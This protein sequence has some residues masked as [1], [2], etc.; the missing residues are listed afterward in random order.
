MGQITRSALWVYI[1]S[2]ISGV[3]GYVFWI[4]ASTF[5]SPNAVGSA[6]AILAFQ[7]L[8]I[9]VSSLGIPTGVKRFVGWMQKGDDYG[10]GSSYFVT[11]VAMIFLL[12]LPVVFAISL[13]SM[14]SIQAFGMTSA[15]LG[16]VSILMLLSF[17]PP[18]LVSLFDSLLK[19]EVT[20]L[21]QIASTITKLMIGIVLL[22]MGF[23]FLGLMIALIAASL[24]TDLVLLLSLARTASH[25]HIGL[26]FDVQK[27]KDLIRGSIR[28]AYPE[29]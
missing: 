23:D 16:F 5:V 1:G 29:F 4:A 20:S 6:S 10:Q 17:W 22:M 13:L 15:E 24:A 21:A 18:V 12:N 11:A 25:L 27:A 26:G 14:S 9:S 7:G 28:C 3:L 8:I 2:M 19:T